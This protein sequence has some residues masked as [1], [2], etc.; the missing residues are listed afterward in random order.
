MSANQPTAIKGSQSLRTLVI[1]FLS[2]RH[3]KELWNLLTIADPDVITGSETWLKQDIP[4]AEIFPFICNVNRWDG[5]GEVLVATKVNLITHEIQ[6]ATTSET[7]RYKQK[8]QQ[9][10]S[11]WDLCTETHQRKVS[12]MSWSPRS[13]IMLLVVTRLG[14]LIRKMSRIA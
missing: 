1:K 12:T 13:D 9:S 6:H 4:N 5:Y 8:R 11:P 7:V 10:R 14:Q 2:L 3:K